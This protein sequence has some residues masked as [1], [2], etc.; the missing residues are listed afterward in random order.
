M[1]HWH[2]YLKLKAL[3]QGYTTFRYCPPRYVYVY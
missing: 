3:H 2:R 1:K